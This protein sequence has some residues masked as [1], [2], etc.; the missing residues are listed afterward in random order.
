MLTPDGSRYQ[1]GAYDDGDIDDQGDA[2]GYFRAGQGP[3]S[4]DA[5][6]MKVANQWGLVRA[7]D[8]NGNSYT[9]DWTAETQTIAGADP[10]VSGYRCGTNPQFAVDVAET[11]YA[12]SLLPLRMAYGNATV[13]FEY[14]TRGDIP[15]FGEP[16]CEN[17]RQYS[18]R[19]LSAIRV[20]RQG[21]I[22][23]R[24]HLVNSVPAGRRHLEL[25]AIELHGT[26][27]TDTLPAA[28]S[29]SY[30]K[31][32]SDNEVLLE[33]VENGY[34]GSVAFGYAE[35]LLDDA[36]FP[37]CQNDSQRWVVNAR[38]VADGFG[39]A[40]TTVVSYP[41]HGEVTRECSDEDFEFLGFSPVTETLYP[42]GQSSGPAAR[43]STGWFHQLAPGS[44]N[45]ADIRKGKQ[46]LQTIGDGS[47]IV[48]TTDWLWTADG[49]WPRLDEVTTTL[50]G[51]A[52]KTAYGYDQYGNTTYVRE[53]VP[54]ASGLSLYRT[55]VTGY[56]YLL[57]GGGY[58][59]DRPKV[60]RVYQ[61]DETGACVRQTEYDYGGGYGADPV[62]PANLLGQRTPIASCNDTT[63]METRYGYADGDGSGGVNG[64]VTSV[65]V[66]NGSLDRETRTA[67]YAPG[68]DVQSV[69]EEN[70]ANDLVTSYSYDAY[71]RLA[72]TIQPN[73]L[74][75]RFSYDPFGRP[76]QV[77]RR[78]IGVSA[79]TPQTRWAYSDSDGSAAACPDLGFPAGAGG[80][81][82]GVLRQEVND[83]PVAGYDPPS[84]ESNSDPLAGGL[85]SFTFYDGLG[86]PV[87]EQQERNHA[88]NP[89]TTRHTSYDALGQT[90][91]EWLPYGAG[92]WDGSAP[93]ASVGATSYQVDPL[94]RVLLSTLPDGSQS[95]MGYSKDSAGL[96]R[97]QVATDANGHRV[98]RFYDVLGRLD[99]VA[100]RSGSGPAYT[101]YANT[102][103]G[104]DVLD[105]LTDVWDHAGNH[106]AIVYDAAGRKTS[107]ADPDMG[108]WRYG[109]D[110]AGNLTTQ[111][112]ALADATCTYYD[113]LQRLVRKKTVANV[114]SPASYT[115][116][117][118]FA[119]YD[120]SFGYDT[121]PNGLG[122]RCAASNANA[123]ISTTYNNRGLLYGETKSGLPGLAGSY[124]AYRLYDLLDRPNGLQYPDGDTVTWS[125]D[126]GGQPYGL[127]GGGEALVVSSSYRPWG[128]L[129]R[130][131]LG[132]GLALDDDYD[133]GERLWL[134]RRQVGTLDAQGNLARPLLNLAYD[135]DRVG[136]VLAI[137]DTL[138]SEVHSY[139]YDHR[140]RLTEWRLN[141]AL[142]QGY[143]YNEI[144]NITSF[145]GVAYSYPAAGQGRP[146]AVTS[147]TTG[148]SFSYNLA[149][150][151]TSRRDRAGA[152]SWTYTWWENHKLKQI[153]N[154]ATDDVAAFLYGP[155]DER[156]K[157][158]SGPAGDTYDT[159]YLF[160][161]YQVEKG[162]LRADVDC[163]GDVDVM[164]IQKV[165]SR[166]NTTYIAYEQDGANPISV[167]DIS[168]VAEKWLWEGANSAGQVVK[169]YSLGGRTVAVNRGGEWTYVF[170]DH[171][172]S[173]A[174][175][176]DYNGRAG[177]RWKYEPYGTMRGTEWTLPIDKGF[178]GQVIEPGLGLHDYGAR[179]YAQP[180]GRW[181]AP[182]TLVP[183]PMDPQALN[184]YSY[185]LNNP[186]RYNDP[187]G[188]DWGDTVDFLLGFGAQWASANA[189]M[190]PQAQ[191]ALSVQPNESLPMTVG[192]HLG[193]V[194]AI[195]QGVAEVGVG[196]SVDVG[197]GGLCLTGVGCLAG[198]PAVVAGTALAAH[199]ATVAVAGA[200]M[201][202]QMLGNLLMASGSGNRG[203][204][205]GQHGPQFSS[206]TVWQG[207]N[208]RLDVENPAPGRRSGQI[209]LQESGVKGHKWY[210][211]PE[212]GTFMPEKGT[213]ILPPGWV[214]RLLKDKDFLA[215]I[216]KALKYLGESQ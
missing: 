67:Y 176:T 62:A 78:L 209:H 93:P 163:D 60:Q 76:C 84:G 161:F 81:Q 11:F 75:Q 99:E 104:Y 133:E 26:G 211:N 171:L 56:G 130:Q 175:E 50:D 91:A 37:N 119:S 146:H 150:Y 157:K 162:C 120:A 208:A 49:N 5:K 123:S 170:Q 79:W 135:Y 200:A 155:D 31:L 69:T 58:I 103:Y 121:C 204:M 64:N 40:V 196:A 181:I 108:T 3:C 105:Q 192:R 68:I 94:G 153:S 25:A 2:T 115:C 71:G 52:Q 44:W 184:R 187:S 46:D 152:V 116:P 180:L 34:G 197:G 179:H 70:G 131:R 134:T 158:S 117:A 85:A 38:H 48:Q 14:E 126:A 28:Y 147:T 61:G 89:W 97:S 32:G 151:M 106:T 172:G 102:S 174:L 125:Y 18:V 212:T 191:E 109:Y 30:D 53:Y 65:V 59:V 143:S 100:E 112:D 149:G 87:A 16:I 154:S 72:E 82:F 74:R 207:G 47:A 201:E 73:G 205:L 27:A 21:E 111:V 215:A 122:Q 206:K 77:E 213:G 182:D 22:V 92:L 198:A 20:E 189:W 186:L 51:V 66:E 24:Y 160:P 1:F 114:A 19:M 8:T 138:V 96:R 173:P 9:A 101:P 7:E 90:A 86:R 169:T 214:E 36:P 165:A 190:A 141:G 202:G 129:D 137:S 167:T 41:P 33:R 145:A 178:T 128:A 6:W 183:D 42:A 140:D 168:L 23:R 142:L 188:H 216:E 136:N 54:T 194:A 195:M 210:Y 139:V 95:S 15:P 10:S 110:L 43:V 159:Y 29:F 12:R 199:G 39:P 45:Q 127:G 164:D 107:M 55:T 166:F 88:S 83:S 4:R 124:T 148:G 185:V 177:F 57:S 193:N 98:V 13:E 156:V 113:R 132:N 80:G 17:Q 118:S 144:G 63:Y 35:K 203:A